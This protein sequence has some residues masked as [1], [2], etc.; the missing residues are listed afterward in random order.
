M[1]VEKC[2][3]LLDI[4]EKSIEDMMQN[5][6]VSVYTEQLMNDKIDQLVSYWRDNYLDERCFNSSEMK[7]VIRNKLLSDVDFSNFL[8][9]FVQAKEYIEESMTDQTEESTILKVIADR[10]DL[11]YGKLIN[12]SSIAEASQICREALE[13]VVHMKTVI[14]K[15]NK[16]PEP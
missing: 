1:K 12:I 14:E 7:S 16:D 2:I 9:K 5:L 15:I 13:E 4:M 10:V 6:F 11:H 8:N 3:D